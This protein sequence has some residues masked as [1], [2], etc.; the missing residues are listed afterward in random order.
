MVARSFSKYSMVSEMKGGINFLAA[1]Y[2][3]FQD[4]EEI[5][6]TANRLVFDGLLD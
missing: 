6:A 1:N 4:V 2:D 3:L 5:R